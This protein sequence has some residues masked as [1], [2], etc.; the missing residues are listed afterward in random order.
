MVKH[1]A[2]S[3][4]SKHGFANLRSADRRFKVQTTWIVVAKPRPGGNRRIQ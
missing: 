1:L 2:I 4:K 3:G